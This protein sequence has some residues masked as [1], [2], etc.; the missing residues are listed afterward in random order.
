MV[1]KTGSHFS[2]LRTRLTI[3]NADA[4]SAMIARVEI[5]AH[6]LV[7]AADTAAMRL[8]DFGRK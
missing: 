6:I 7:V 1:R 4:P 2:G 5:R 3:R 8:L